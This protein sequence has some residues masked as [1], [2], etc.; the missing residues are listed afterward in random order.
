MS[1]IPRLM[2]KPAEPRHFLG[3]AGE[4]ERGEL[5]STLAG[6]LVSQSRTSVLR[7]RECPLFSVSATAVGLASCD[8]LEKDCV[9]TED[10]ARGVR[11]EFKGDASACF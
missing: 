9:M 2:R 3:S 1:S 8:W 4:M 5:Q 6:S 11:A 10:K 7:P